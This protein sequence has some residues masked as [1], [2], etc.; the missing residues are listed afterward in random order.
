MVDQRRISEMPVQY[1]STG[2]RQYR[3]YQSQ[4]LKNDHL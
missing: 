3:A 4:G 1:A 2:I